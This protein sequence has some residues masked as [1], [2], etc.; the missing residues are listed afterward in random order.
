MIFHDRGNPVN[1]L[2]KNRFRTIWL[3]PAVEVLLY[4]LSSTGYTD[5]AHFACETTVFLDGKYNIT[6]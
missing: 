5:F 2:K 4:S 1:D 6:T 3:S